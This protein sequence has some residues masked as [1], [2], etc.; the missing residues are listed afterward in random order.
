MEVALSK[1]LSAKESI[2]HMKISGI[3]PYAVVRKFCQLK[4]WLM[5]ESLMAAEAQKGLIER[6]H[7]EVGKNGAISFSSAEMVSEFEKGWREILDSKIEC[8]I[9]KLDLSNHKDYIT[10]DSSAVDID[11]LANFI[12]FE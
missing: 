4:E 8:E 11:S 6:T 12:I 3:I 9:E 7:G 2:L 1:V 10:F 5:H